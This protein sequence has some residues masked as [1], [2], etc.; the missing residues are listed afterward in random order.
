MNLALLNYFIRTDD[1]SFISACHK[2]TSQ[3]V[4]IELKYVHHHLIEHGG[5]SRETKLY[6][7]VQRYFRFVVDGGVLADALHVAS[8]RNGYLNAHVA[9]VSAFIA[10]LVNHVCCTRKAK[11]TA[12]HCN[13]ASNLCFFNLT[14]LPPVPAE[15]E[16]LLQPVSL[17]Q[18]W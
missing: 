11:T 15:P 17:H 16:K 13:P 7:W 9:E 2:H 18:C 3:S 4:Y 14:C 6:D 12:K 5:L 8:K 1:L 10:I